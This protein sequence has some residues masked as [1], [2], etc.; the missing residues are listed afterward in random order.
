MYDLNAFERQVEV[1]AQRM[2]GPSQTVDDAAVFAAIPAARFPRIGLG[3]AFSAAKYVMAI[4]I[5]ALFGGVLFSGILLAPEGD[6]DPAAVTASPSPVTAPPS[7]AGAVAPAFPAGTFVSEED[8]RTLEFRE[9]GTCVRAGTPCTYTISERY[10]AEMTFEDDTPGLRMPATYFWQFDGEELT[11][12]QRND[13]QRLDR[14]ETYLDH[15]YRLAGE[16]RPLPPIESDFPTGWFASA[17]DPS[18][19]I[20]FAKNGRWTLGNDTGGGSWAVREDVLTTTSTQSDWSLYPA[21]FYWDWDG[22]RLTFEPWGLDP[23]PWWPE[24]QKDYVRDEAAVKPRSFLLSDPRIEYFVR[25]E[26]RELEGGSFVANS[27]IDEEPLGE[28]I[29]DTLHEAVR[30]S[31]AEL[32]EPLASDLAAKVPG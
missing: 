15:V 5:L 14:K 31:L 24:F 25:V 10:F 7:P 30:A 22:E 17:D 4:G 21:T 12:E 28:A 8:G 20:L 26:T 23:Q 18:F 3:F 19:T 16:P 11:F 27:S 2:A 13:D 32:G 9:D 29:G 1:E 6:Q